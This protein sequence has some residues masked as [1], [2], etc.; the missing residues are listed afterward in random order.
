ML[1]QQGA[2]MPNVQ[3][4]PVP[5]ETYYSMVNSGKDPVTLFNNPHQYEAQ[6]P[7]QTVQMERPSYEHFL[8]PNFVMPK[9]ENFKQIEVPASSQNPHELVDSI[10]E[11]HSF[12]SLPR[13][14]V[15]TIMIKESPSHLSSRSTEPFINSAN[16]SNVQGP[17]PYVPSR[18]LISSG[19]SSS[20]N[21]PVDVL[22]LLQH[23]HAMHLIGDKDNFQV[24]DYLITMFKFLASRYLVVDGIRFK[25]N[26]LTFSDYAKEDAMTSQ[27]V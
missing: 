20:N 1:Q 9:M 5:A 13:P 11:G 22:A 24:I 18:S 19:S 17:V 27:S 12:G 6:Q 8:T 14:P 16:S 26:A 21:M 3:F 7:Q 2:Q 15:A 25:G 4:V 10:S 23:A